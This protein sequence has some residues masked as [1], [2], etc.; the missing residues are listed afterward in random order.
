MF[1][2][3][4]KN[5]YGILLFRRYHN[6]IQT[7]L[8]QKRCTY[9]YVDFILNKYNPLSDS[10]L[11]RLFNKM[12]KEEKIIIKSMNFSFIWYHYY[13][14]TPDPLCICNNTFNKRKKLFEKTFF[15]NGR[16]H[17]LIDHSRSVERVWE[18]PKGRKNKNEFKLE[19]SIRELEEET[20]IKLRDIQFVFDKPIKFS[21]EDEGITYNCYYYTAFYIGNK[22]IS[23]S[24]KNITQRDS[25]EILECKWVNRNEC[26]KLVN[27]NLFQKI[28]KYFKQIK[29]L[30]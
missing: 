17:H 13:L 10:S 12:T 18:L 24:I 2:K 1:N 25:G 6:E 27:P 19:T 20:G 3:R 9:A 28:D 4:V 22:E 7:L 14:E 29:T 21:H 23:N 11:V 8:V 15:G 5:S 30:I 16:L 26:K